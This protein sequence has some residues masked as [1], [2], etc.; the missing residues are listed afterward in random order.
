MAIRLRHART[1]GWIKL[2]VY[3][4]KHWNYRRSLAAMTYLQVHPNHPLGHRRGH[5]GTSWRRNEQPRTKFGSNTGGCFKRIGSVYG[6][7]GWKLFLKRFLCLTP[8]STGAGCRLSPP[9]KTRGTGE[10]RYPGK[11]RHAAAIF[12]LNCRKKSSRSIA[13]GRENVRYLQYCHLQ[14]RRRDQPAPTISRS[15]LL[16]R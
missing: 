10:D 12:V 4:C 7:Y 1:S 14:Y 6:G 5:A 11:R 2:T 15:L 9:K 3:T 13:P 16:N 8:C